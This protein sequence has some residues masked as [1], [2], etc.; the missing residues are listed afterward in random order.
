MSLN[1]SQTPS[2]HADPTLIPRTHIEHE[3][4]ARVTP[5]SALASLAGRVSACLVI[6]SDLIARQFPRPVVVAARAPYHVHSKPGARQPRHGDIAPNDI[7]L[8]C[9]HAD[10]WRFMSEP[11]LSD[12]LCE[13]MNRHFITRKQPALAPASSASEL[14]RRLSFPSNCGRASPPLTCNATPLKIQCAVPDQGAQS[15]HIGKG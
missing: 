5:R 9:R 7:W 8:P 15:R 11:P 13:N 2:T 1:T 12:I 10:G 14:T 3:G 4:T 6:V